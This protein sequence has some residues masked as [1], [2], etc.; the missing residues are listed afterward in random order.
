[1]RCLRAICHASTAWETIQ[2]PFSSGIT[3]FLR[4]SGTHAIREAAAMQRETS[5][6]ANA[7]EI[8]GRR[9]MRW[10]ARYIVSTIFAPKPLQ[11]F[12]VLN[13]KQSR[14]LPI[15]RMPT[16]KIGLWFV[17]GW[18]EF[19]RGRINEARDSA[20]ELMQ[21]GRLLDDPRSTGLG[22]NLLTWIALTAEF[23]C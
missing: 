6:M 12:E 2:E 13:E 18:D 4:C 9:H 19:H 20:R 5:P 1:M 23:L 10:R 21:V 14:P 3:M 15:R 22:L 11:E 7:S 16:F 8:A 17:I